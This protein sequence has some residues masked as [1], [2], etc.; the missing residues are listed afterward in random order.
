M[1]KAASVL[2]VFAF[3]LASGA[4][5]AP[6]AKSKSADLRYGVGLS[7]DR[8]DLRVE[9]DKLNAFGGYIT[10]GSAND[11]DSTI[12]GLGGYYLKR[13]AEPKPVALHMM[14]G[15]S[16]SS[17][18]NWGAALPGAGMLM[19][20]KVTIFTLFG[21]IGAEY[22]LPGTNQL[23]IEANVGLG[24]DI[25]GGDADGIGFSIRN[26]E[27]GLVMIRYYFD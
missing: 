4:M 25:Y 15:A 13:F 26:I 18:D 1:R 6:A 23:S 2:A 14:G 22:F 24:I 12:F 9:L 16:I 3:L 7:L 21:A 27:G 5:A 11:G 19:G 10:F 17:A 20:G 8:A